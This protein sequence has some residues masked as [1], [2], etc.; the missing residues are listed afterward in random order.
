MGARC[1]EQ[2]SYSASSWSELT[3]QGQ[4]DFWIGCWEQRSTQGDLSRGWDRRSGQHWVFVL[5]LEAVS[6]DKLDF[7]SGTRLTV[8]GKLGA[9]DEGE[10]AFPCWESQVK[11][12]QG[13]FLS[14][15]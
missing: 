5:R 14:C 1:S 3:C 8:L 12:S 6:A 2:D 4:E 10:G 7:G 15:A 13:Q 11:D 9:S